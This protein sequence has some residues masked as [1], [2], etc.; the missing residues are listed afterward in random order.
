MFCENCGREIPEDSSYCAYCG[1][2]LPSAP[3]ELDW[4]EAARLREAA[5]AAESQPQAE[6]AVHSV[7]GGYAPE[8]VT[9]GAPRKQCARCGRSLPASTIG[10][11]CALCTMRQSQ[12]EDKRLQQA[13]EEK[14][15][16]EA[17]REKRDRYHAADQLDWR[18]YEN[19]TAAAPK[20]PSGWFHEKRSRKAAAGGKRF[21]CAG[22]LPVFIF[23]LLIPLLPQAAACMEGFIT[24]LSEK[25]IAVSQRESDFQEEE[26][27]E[28][29][30]EFLYWEDSEWTSRD[31]GPARQDMETFTAWVR[32][33]AIWMLESSLPDLSESY[34]PLFL[35][36]D[37]VEWYTDGIKNRVKGNIMCLDA[38]GV[39][40]ALPFDTVIVVTGD[41]PEGL[42]YGL[43]LEINSEILFDAL[44]AVDDRG[45]VTE[46]GEIIFE[47]PR[48]AYPYEGARP[49]DLSSGA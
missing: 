8:C 16:R 34:M 35:E 31:W 9:P 27:A 45:L 23:V 5:E 3:R 29:F 2:T 32:P 40:V 25:T 17:A 39:K 6:A 19:Q 15:E 43:C 44:E 22:C 33:L 36:D 41:E 24:G 7:T 21:G 20:T 38:Q 48:G 46:L 30:E 28:S 26:D 47:G 12:E 10:E 18:A 49:R 42:G 4:E 13:A 11:Y 14:Y 37:S 1:I